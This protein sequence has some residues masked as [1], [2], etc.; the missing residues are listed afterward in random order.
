MNKERIS[1]ISII[2]GI[3]T[4]SFVI[5][6][7]L[8]FKPIERKINNFF[9]V[10]LGGKKMGLIKSEEELH[11]IIDEEQKEIKEKYGVD[12]VYS[13]SGLE[14]HAISTYK[15][16][17][18]TAKEMYE[19][20]KD[21]EPFTIEGYEV[22]IKDKTDSLKNKKV[23]LLN[24]DMLDEA[25]KNTVLAFV[26]DK[27]YDNY[28]SGKTP[29]IVDTGREITNIY[30]ENEVTIKKTYISAEENIISDINTL[31]MYFLF[32]TDTI[33]N[34]YKVKPTDTIETIAYNNKLGVEDLLIANPDL[35]GKNA[36]L[37][38]GQEVN[39]APIKPLSNI[40]VES[41]DTEYQTIKYETKAEF[42]KTLNADQSYVKQQGTNGLSKVVYATKQVNGVILAT[43]LVSEEVISKTVDKIVVYGAKNV[44]YY[45]NTTYWAWPTSRPFRISSGYGYRSHPIRGEYHF[46]PALDITG[47]PKYDIYSIQD[48]TVVKAVQTGYNGGNG[49][50]VTIDHGNG[51]VASYLHLK[52]NSIKVKQGE[53]VSKGQIIGTMGCTGSC[54]GTHLDFRIKKNGEY[55]NPMNLYK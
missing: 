41:F 40:V 3:V 48:G 55:I 20:I 43:S 24:K 16:N 46:H 38:A 12:K 14:I 51:Y 22:T 4:I 21:V 8:T 17:L 47:V 13:P 37:A 36:L 26:D 32:G 23:Y 42:D 28:L 5:Y 11:N 53:K 35:G 19:K 44:V 6:M 1:L 30:L 29:E 34:T 15:D 7:C 31:S 27:E 50:Y 52:K 10:Y 2:T 18:M 9:Q 33:N 49:S 25:V 54:S 45:G 39:V